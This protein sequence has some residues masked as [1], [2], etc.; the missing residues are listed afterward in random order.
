MYN[1]QF[2]TMTSRFSPAKLRTS[3]RRSS[4]ASSSSQDS[5]SP[6]SAT[7]L[8]SQTNTINKIMRKQPSMLHLEA[9]RQSF[10]SELDLLEPRPIVYW[11]SVEERITALRF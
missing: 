9:E 7:T 3:F 10:G 4:S 6:T 1:S 2:Q 11:G 5:Y 8:S